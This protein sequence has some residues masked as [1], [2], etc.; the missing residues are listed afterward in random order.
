MRMRGWSM[1]QG[2]MEGSAGQTNLR[3]A[4]VASPSKTVSA[5]KMTAFKRTQILCILAKF[6]YVYVDGY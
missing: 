5:K 6:L 2:A 3:A 4:N 1:E